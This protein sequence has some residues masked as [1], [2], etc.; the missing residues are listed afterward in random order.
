MKVPS[1]LYGEKYSGVYCIENSGG[2]EGVYRY[3][4][5]SIDLYQRM[6]KHGSLLRHNVHPNNKLQ[7]SWNNLE[8]EKFECY[9]IEFCNKEILTKRE[10]LWI[11]KLNP[12]YNINLDA[13]KNTPSKKSKEKISE[14]LKEGYR[15]GRIKATKTRS[16]KVYNLQ[17]ELLG[18]YSTKNEA[19]LACK[20]SISNVSRVL[21]GRFKQ[22]NGFQF[23]YAEDT[24]PVET[25][26]RNKYPAPVKLDELLENLEVDNQQPSYGST[27]EYI[28]GS[29]TNS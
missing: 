15:T 9:V 3:I 23:K 21:I 4:G 25:I 17:A 6:H 8:E 13:I 19:S 28:E 12:F 10:Q 26:Q 7:E 5:S 29:E 11:D 20:T 24:T 27:L 14:T 2:V 16:V 22:A 1:Y 18:E